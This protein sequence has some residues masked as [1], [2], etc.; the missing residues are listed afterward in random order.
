M[1]E[2]P[3]LLAHT[4]IQTNKHAH[5]FS[6]KVVGTDDSVQDRDLNNDYFFLFGDGADG[7]GTVCSDTQ[8]YICS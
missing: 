7:G 5:R 8:L 4:H 1:C 2:F 6:R 3:I